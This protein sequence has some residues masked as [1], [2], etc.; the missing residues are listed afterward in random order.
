MPEVR[1]YQNQ[2][3]HSAFSAFHLLEPTPFCYSVLTLVG[4]AGLSVSILN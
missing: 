3:G 1:P 2:A 4:C